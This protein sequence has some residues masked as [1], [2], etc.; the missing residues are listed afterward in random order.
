MSQQT[1]RTGRHPRRRQACYGGDHDLQVA[2][3]GQGE[4]RLPAI[5]I[6]SYVGTHAAIIVE[7]EALCK[8]IYGLAAMTVGQITSSAGHGGTAGGVAT[9]MDAGMMR[10]IGHCVFTGGHLV[11]DTGHCVDTTG[12]CVLD[13]GHCVR[14][15]T[16]LEITSGH[17]VSDGGQ[18]VGEVG[19]C[20]LTTGHW[21]ELAG[22]FVEDVGH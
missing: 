18:N 3:G 1:D 13:V 2:P 11:A 10:Q 20:V 15:I 19:H 16:H 14:M 12:H 4:V 17:F 9:A 7:T 22:H 5:R 6:A 21:V 8:P